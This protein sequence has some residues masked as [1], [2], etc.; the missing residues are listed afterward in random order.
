MKSFYDLSK[1]PLETLKELFIEAL[2]LSEKNYMNIIPKEKFIRV[3][4]KELTPLEYINT[5]LTK[6][7]H[8]VLINRW[9]YNNRAHWAEKICEV[10]SSTFIDNLALYIYVSLENMELLV[11][12]YKL[13]LC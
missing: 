1:L 8:N 9:D 3:M 12:K 7:C 11:N 4:Y 2:S 10:G 6:Q 13:E 5:K